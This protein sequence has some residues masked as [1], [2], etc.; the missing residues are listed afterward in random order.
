MSV[1]ERTIAFLI[2]GDL[3]HPSGGYGYARA[4]MAEWR[5]SGRPFR[6]VALPGGF[7]FPSE[8]A[9]DE[10]ARILNGIGPD[11]I[12]LVDGLAYGALPERVLA[13]ARAPLDVLLHHPLGLETGLDS[14]TADGLIES[15]RRAL[16][17]ARRIVVTSPETARTVVRLFDIDAA[18]ITVALPGTSPRPA[19]LRDADPPLIASVGSLTPRKGYLDL[20]AAL[21]EL[22][23]LAWHAEIAG[24][25]TA[26][27]E[28][29]EAV[30][31]AIVAAGLGQRIDLRGALSSD[32]V[33]ALYGRAS[34][35]ALASHYEGY[36]MAFAEAM[37]AGLPIVGCR[38]GAVADVVPPEAG[39]LVEPGDRAALSEALRRILA[40]PA[41][42]AQM[43]AASR[44]AGLALPQWSDTA[45]RIADALLTEASDA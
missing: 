5:R 11:E 30:R 12:V 38:G 17:H 20:V 34:L 33:D 31:R 36:G 15:E 10:T 2:P 44:Q 39:F 7:P 24:S 43:A 26:S 32:A 45:C 16:R 1:K 28:T 21:A 22:K 35:F 4:V 3:Y 8:E 19:S 6:H 42:A 37:S 41:L 18:A 9:L 25:L 27:P 40:A 13:Q 29:A 23:D 14:E